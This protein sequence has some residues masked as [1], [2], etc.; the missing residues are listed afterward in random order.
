MAR[1]EGIEKF[2]LPTLKYFSYGTRLAS[3]SKKWKYDTN[4]YA[5]CTATNLAKAGFFYSGTKKEPMAAKCFV[6]THELIWDP[7][8]QPLEEH[9]KHRPD[10]VLVKL[11]GEKLEENFTIKDWLSCLTYASSTTQYKVITESTANLYAVCC[12]F[13]SNIEKHL[14]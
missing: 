9:R 11:L 7:E 8:D 1:N 6:C 14:G 10:C 4:K 3:F 2:K 13:T 5:N 12:K